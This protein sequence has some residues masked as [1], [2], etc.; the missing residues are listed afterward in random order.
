MEFAVN[1]PTSCGT[2]EYSTL[3]FCE[4]I[5]WEKQRDFSVKIEELGFDGIAVPDHLMTGDGP[6]TE[7]LVTTTGLAGITSDVYLYP[8]TINNHLRHGPLLAKI[9]ATLD[10]VSDGRLKLGM[11]A[12]WKEDEATAYGYEWPDAPTRLRE[13]EETIEVMKHL[14]TETNVSYDGEFYTLSEADCRPHP[15]QDPH[16]P[17]M[18]G[19][20]GEEF[21]LRITA[22]HGDVW[23]YWGSLELMKRKLSVLSNHCE[24]YGRDYDDIQKSWFARCI[25][26]ESDEN[27]SELLDSAPRFKSENRDADQNHLVGTPEEIIAEIKQYKDLGIDEI[28]V[29]FVDFPQTEGARCFAE[30]VIPEF[31]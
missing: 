13:M 2:S 18:I 4:D 20:G 12:G 24:T 8:K 3:A 6:T 19:G 27:V 28:V 26:R 1:I 15:L 25:I 22:K 10:C 5:S 21:T 16:P 30:H 11:G 17:I 29:E 31:D 14:W 9:A 7:C 23:N